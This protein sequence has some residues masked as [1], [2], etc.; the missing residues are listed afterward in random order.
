MWSG[1]WSDEDEVVLCEG[2]DVTEQRQAKQKL[3]EKDERYSA[4]IENGSDMIALFDKKLNFLYSSGS[5]FKKLGYLPEQVIGTNAI[6]YI[7]PDDIPLIKEALSKALIS[8]DEKI[9]I[10]EFRYKDPKGEWRWLKTIVSNQLSN[11]AIK[12]FV[13]SSLDITGRVNNRLKLQESEQR[14][15][16]LFATI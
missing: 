4:L 11:P 12:A 14:F 3:I 2:R 6:N 8:G 10:S 1:V 16:S 9:K 15:K 7:H 13:T 5:T